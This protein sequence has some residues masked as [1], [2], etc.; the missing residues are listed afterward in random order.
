MTA[1]TDRMSVLAELLTAHRREIGSAVDG[2]IRDGRHRQPRE[3]GDEL[4]RSLLQMRADTVNR[5]D[6]ALARLAA[7]QYGACAVCGLE[8]SERRLRGLPFA[9]R[10]KRCEDRREENN[11][12]FREFAKKAGSFGLTHDSVGA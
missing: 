2:R 7:H 12:R 5:I 9:V 11:D 4:E 10:C 3:V 6:D 8:I 1:D